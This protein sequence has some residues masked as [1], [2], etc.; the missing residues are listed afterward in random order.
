VL[1]S[2]ILFLAVAP[3]SKGPIGSEGAENNKTTSLEIIKKKKKKIH[4]VK[5]LGSDKL[6]IGISVVIVE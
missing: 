1:S 5:L 6:C 2:V 3:K 4:S